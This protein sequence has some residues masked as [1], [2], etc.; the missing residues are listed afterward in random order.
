MNV[1]AAVSVTVRSESVHLRPYFAQ[2]LNGRFPVNVY[3][4]RMNSTG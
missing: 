3:V 2:G 4:V 1:T